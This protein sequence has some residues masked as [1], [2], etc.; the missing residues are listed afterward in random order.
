M[1]SPGEGWAVGDAFDSHQSVI[2]HDTA[3]VWQQVASPTTQPMQSVVGVSASDVWAVGLAGTILHYNGAGWR[4]VN[5][6]R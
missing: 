3:G 6:P 4:I 5:G 1:V 2:L